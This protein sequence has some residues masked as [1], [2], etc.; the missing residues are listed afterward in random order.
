MG[1]EIVTCLLLSNIWRDN[2][3]LFTC[4]CALECIYTLLCKC[5]H[6]LTFCTVLSTTCKSDFKKSVPKAKMNLDRK[7]Q[8]CICP[9][10]ISW[11]V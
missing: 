7:V 5:V 11:L 8:I 6:S 3:I 10:F 2:Y 1:A 9:Y 4:K